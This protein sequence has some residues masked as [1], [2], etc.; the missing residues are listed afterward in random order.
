MIGKQL[1]LEGFNVHR[2]HG[3]WQEAF[4]PMDEWIKEVCGTESEVCSDILPYLLSSYVG[5]DQVS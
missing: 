5:Q 2:W 1:K 3:R 4:L